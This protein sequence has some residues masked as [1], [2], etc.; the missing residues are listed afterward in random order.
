M[1]IKATIIY[2][3]GKEVILC[4]E[5]TSLPIFADALN[6]RS[7]FWDNDNDGFWTDITKVRYVKFEKIIPETDRHEKC[8]L[9]R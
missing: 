3:D 5:D 8:F 6:T 2:D 4:L 7:A 9:P 1:K